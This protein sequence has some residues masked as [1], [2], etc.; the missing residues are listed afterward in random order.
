MRTFERIRKRFRDVAFTYAEATSAL[1]VSAFSLTSAIKRNSD[2]FVRECFGPRNAFAMFAFKDSPKALADLKRRLEDAKLEQRRTIVERGQAV[3]VSDVVELLHI[4]HDSARLLLKKLGWVPTVIESEGRVLGGTYVRAPRPSGI[5][6]SGR[7]EE[8]RLRREIRETTRRRKGAKNSAG[9]R[10]LNAYRGRPVLRSELIKKARIPYRLFYPAIKASGLVAHFAPSNGGTRS[11][12]L[13]AFP[14][15]EELA[16]TIIA[17]MQEKADD[18]DDP[19]PRDE[20]TL[21]PQL[22]DDVR[23]RYEEMVAM[24]ADGMYLNYDEK[25]TKRSNIDRT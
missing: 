5:P 1:G 22:F 13:Y 12:I 16:Q 25:N 23:E 4:G 19:V 17:R 8:T 18:P 24:R 20:I 3:T 14:E 6:R 2:L 10:K 11:V 9:G 15:D 21:E 7:R